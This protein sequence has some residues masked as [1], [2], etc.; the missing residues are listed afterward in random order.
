MGSSHVQ[1]PG[2]AKGTTEWDGLSQREAYEIEENTAS[3]F[4]KDNGKLPPPREE[5]DGRGPGELLGVVTHQNP[6]LTPWGKGEHQGAEWRKGRKTPFSFPS[7][8]FPGAAEQA[9]RQAK[10]QK[11]TDGTEGSW[12][13]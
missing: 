4:P 5:R 13:I 10:L 11:A 3:S 8:F 9:Q 2:N 12:S 7:W 6:H 1:G